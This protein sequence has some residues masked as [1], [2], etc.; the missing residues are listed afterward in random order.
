MKYT[1]N[2]AAFGN[3]HP[4]P[5]EIV[6]KHIKL[7]SSKQLRVILYIFRHLSSAPSAL[8]IAEAVGISEYDVND[9]LIYWIGAGVL[10]S[11]EPQPVPQKAEEPKKARKVLSSTSKPSLRDVGRR[12]GEDE[13][14]RLLLNLAQEKF[15]RLLKDNESITLLWLYDDEGMDTS[16]ILMLLEYC[17]SQ[18]KC[19]LS[20]IERTAV[21]WLNNNISTLA[22]ADKYI[23][24]KTQ[25]KSAW[26]IVEAAFGIEDRMPSS[27]E[28]ELSE[29]WLLDWGFD[30][31]ILRKAYEVCV[32]TKSKFIMSYVK[33]IL[34]GWHNQGFKTASDVV[35]EKPKAKKE[36]KNN[37]ATYDA[38]LI[39]E[40]LKKGYGNN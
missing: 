5:D 9:A 38:D 21:D 34:E 6:D 10:S 36:N 39:E 17:I 29:L 27:S 23:T 8:E 3:T 13:K 35:L 28:L 32:D 20:Y 24:R 22:D 1:I 18:N 25:A 7:A 14:F 30:K 31:D 16:L 12:A 11:A 37:M 33:K 4:L 15:G 26:K 40:I 19:T 2:I